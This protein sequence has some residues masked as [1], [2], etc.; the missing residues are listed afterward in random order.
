MSGSGNGDGRPK[1]G[2]SRLLEIGPIWITA[3][4]SLIVALTA[5]GFLVGHATASSGTAAPQPSITVAKTVPTSSTS[6]VSPTSGNPSASSSGTIYLTQLNPLQSGA[7]GV[8]DGPVQIGTGTYVDSIS[9]PCGE[10]AAE[11]Q[12]AVYDVAGYRYLTAT[13]GIPNNDPDGTNSAANVVFYKDGSSTTLGPPVSSTVGS[14]QPVHVDLQGAAQ[15]TISCSGA[16][17]TI[18]LGD[19]ALSTS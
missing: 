16:A 4:S 12:T 14:G 17:T 11:T 1:S 19:A 15:L 2:W 18:A 3:I 8:T 5:A 10:A 7:Y 13:V 6:A 9:F